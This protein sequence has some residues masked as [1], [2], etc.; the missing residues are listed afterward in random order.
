MTSSPHVWGGSVP[1]LGVC[2]CIV[3]VEMRSSGPWPETEIN[4]TSGDEATGCQRVA[5]CINS[6][7]EECKKA[8]A[9]Y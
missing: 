9:G 2:L 5:W 4:T 7:F 3:V 6:V 8:E 1:P